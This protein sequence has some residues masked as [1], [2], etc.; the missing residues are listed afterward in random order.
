[1]DK[2][3]QAFNDS[4][5]EFI[6]TGFWFK[7]ECVKIGFSYAEVDFDSNDNSISIGTDCESALNE[8]I[9]ENWNDFFE[10]FPNLEFILTK[11]LALDDNFITWGDFKDIIDGKLKKIIATL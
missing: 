10:H 3:E 11:D 7:N 4:L 8:Y 5:N 6:V 2:Y 9:Y 1:M